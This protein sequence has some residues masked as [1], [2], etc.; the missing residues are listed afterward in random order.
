MKKKDGS[1][2]VEVTIIFMLM[3][4]M[5]LIIYCVSLGQVKAE[6]EMVND[7]IAASELAAFKNIDNDVLGK[8]N[9]LNEIIITNYQETFDTFQSY[10]K[11][12]L[13][14]ND[15]FMPNSKANFIKSK[16][17]I[18]DFRIYNVRGNDVE[19]ITYNNGSFTIDDTNKNKKGTIKTPKGYT[20]DYTTIYAKIGFDI[21]PI[22]NEKKHIVSEEEANIEK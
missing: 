14:I 9:N 7:D 2:V 15:E 19:V 3:M 10:L 12:N 18:V 11:E 17:Q 1:I 6:S 4:I 22:F 8:S 16:V 21:N 5:I 13:N 20:V